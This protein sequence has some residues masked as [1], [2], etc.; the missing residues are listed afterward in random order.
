MY[1]E[2]HITACLV[3]SALFGWMRHASP[4]LEGVACLPRLGTEWQSLGHFPMPLPPRAF[5]ADVS[6]PYA[7]TE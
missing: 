2:A 7:E 4:S 3:I 6:A 5:D 1:T